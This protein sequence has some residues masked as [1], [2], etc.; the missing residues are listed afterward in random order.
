MRWATS[1]PT[2]PRPI[3]PRVLP[4]NSAPWKRERSQRPSRS[5][6][7]ACGML[8]TWARIRAMVCSAAEMTLDWGA[9]TTMIPSRVAV[10]RSTLSRPMPARPT[11]LRLRAASRTSASTRAA[12]SSSRRMP[13]RASTRCCVRSSSMPA[14]A[15]GSAIRTKAMAR[16]VL[17]PAEPGH[18]RPQRP[19]DLLDLV[20]AGLGAQA[21]E[22]G[23]AG[24]VLGHQ[25]AGEGAG[26]DLLEDAFHLRPDGAVDDP[27][28]AGVIAVL[29]G[30]GDRVAHV[31]EAALVE[32]VHDHLELVEA[33]EV[34]DLGLVAGPDKRLEAGLDERAGAAAQHHLLAEQVGLGLLLEGR[35]QRPGAGAADPARVRPGQVP[36][37]AAGVLRDRDQAGRA[38]A[39]LEL[40]AHQVAGALGRDHGH[41]HALRRLDVAEVDVEAV[42]E[43]QRVA[44]LEVGGDVTRV[45]VPLHGVGHQHHD[46]VRPGARLARA[47]HLQAGR[48]GPGAAPGALGEA[49]PH[50]AAGVPEAQRVGVPL[51]AVAEHRDLA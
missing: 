3:T 40:A 14:S 12:S 29:G 8:R 19:A 28:P 51:G 35:D 50:L 24:V 6:A 39:L 43:E 49:D 4:Y 45:Q 36:G 7:S 13:G 44:G 32:Q 48:L 37:L 18:H 27:R 20:V 17:R 16:S 33:L 41:V 34:G 23:P 38:L 47:Q 22:V 9:L 2:R 21:A 26:A 10:A 15:S 5:A 46:Q 11:T 31:A 42:R 30:V 25:L 1:V